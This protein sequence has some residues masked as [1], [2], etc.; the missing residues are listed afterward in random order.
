MWE[1]G[2]RASV[3]MHLPA[4]VLT[5]QFNRIIPT[6]NQFGLVVRGIFGEGSEALGNIFQISNQITLGKSEEEIIE[7]LTTIVQQ[8]I[9]HERS[10]RDALVKT[11]LITA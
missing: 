6:I 3:M 5:K 9:K 11:S 7:D 10:A 2:L 4:L 1:P 8:L